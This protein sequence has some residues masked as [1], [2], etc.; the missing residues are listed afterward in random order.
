MTEKQAV[1][2]IPI[3]KSELEPYERI[4]ILQVKKVLGDRYPIRFVAPKSLKAE[5]LND[6][7]I[8]TV[9]FPDRYFKSIESYCEFCLS[10][11][12]YTTFI[13]YKYILL[14]QTDAFVFKDEL[15]RFMK[16]GYDYIGAPVPKFCWSG[17]EFRVGNGGFSLRRTSAFLWAIE[18]KPTIYEK[19]PQIDMSKREDLY[20]AAVGHQYPDLF[21]IPNEEVAFEFST[22]FD[23]LGAYEKIRQNGLPFGC[24]RWF[25][26]R[27]DFW[28][29][30]IKAFGY[31]I[32]E[33]YIELY[34]NKYNYS[35]AKRNAYLEKMINDDLNGCCARLSTIMNQLLRNL[36]KRVALWGYGKACKRLVNTFQLDCF[37]E[38]WDENHAGGK[39]KGVVLTAPPN[40]I[41]ANT[42]VIITTSKFYR[43]V[44]AFLESRKYIKNVDY[45]DYRDFYE[46]A[47]QIYESKYK[48]NL[49]DGIEAES[50]E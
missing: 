46:Q 19:Y 34:A 38:I 7:I 42:V 4:S 12:F 39:V 37:D 31:K 10:S 44:A 1:V 33:E 16:M 25:D 32:P 48:D 50:I 49:F 41:P 11:D 8:K 40:E 35:L 27:F 21:R 20:F 30:Y 29:D 6:P 24:H 9:R 5:T 36:N 28:W 17:V 23:F 2:V 13:E 15:S 3:Y 18:Q 43:E 47:I 45:F 14:Y 22:E 26:N